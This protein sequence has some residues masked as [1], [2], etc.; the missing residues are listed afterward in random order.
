MKKVYLVTGGSSG[1]GLEVAKRLK[2]G[3]VFIT[4]RRE[5]KLVESVKEL[6]TLGV[7]ADYLQGDL[8]DENRLSEIFKR[9]AEEGKLAGVINSAGVSGVGD[10]VDT[11]LEI[12][13]KGAALLIEEAKKIATK[14]SI[15]VMISS[16][17]GYMVPPNPELDGLLRHPLEEENLRKIKEACQDDSSNAYNISKRGVH[18]LVEENASAFGEKSSRI[19][20]VSPGVIMTPMA[21]EAAK[22]YPE[23]MAFMEQMTPCK[24]SG[25]PEDIANAVE[26]LLSDN[27]SFITGCD[28]RV[29]GGLV[30][31]LPKMAQM[32]E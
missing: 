30:L 19:V 29:D 23:R 31:N 16:M 11:T 3:K 4:G 10:S 6:K 20:S 12:D 1:I 14:G 9:V 22:A 7:D 25:D 5:E 15:I 26:F 8:S 13:L 27:A 32:Q 28:L 24:R 18:L 21:R 17:M 2:D